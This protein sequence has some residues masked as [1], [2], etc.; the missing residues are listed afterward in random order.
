LNSV[1]SKTQDRPRLRFVRP[2]KLRKDGSPDLGIELHTTS[3]SPPGA[4]TPLV[5]ARP[6]Y[7]GAKPLKPILPQNRRSFVATALNALFYGSG[8][9]G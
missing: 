7:H 2:D 9:S 3:T 8:Q 5:G 6:F 1:Y 4:S